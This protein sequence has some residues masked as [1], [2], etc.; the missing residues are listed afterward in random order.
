MDPSS[1]KYVSVILVNWNGKKYLTEV[2]PTLYRQTYA[3]LEIIVV[4]NA[5][6]DGT[7]DYI[8]TEHPNVL[9]IKNPE[10][11]GFCKANNQGIRLSKGGYVLIMNPDVQLREDFIEKMVQAMEREEK[12]GI[13]SGK[14]FR[15]K[16]RTILDTTGIVLKKNR[17]AI[18][19]GQGESDG[20]R[21]NQI[22]EI[23]GASGAACLYRREMLEAVKFREEYLDELFFAYKEDVDLSWRARLL[24]WK[25][26]YTPY[27][28]GYH[29]RTWFQGNRKQVPRWIRRHSLKN[30]Y[31]M[32]I[33]ND[34][35][36]EIRS[37]LKDFLWYELKSLIYILFREPHLFKALFDVIRLLP[38]VLEK[39]KVIQE[40]AKAG[41]KDLI[42]WFQL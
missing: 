6:T 21:Y 35:W 38:Q 23:F 32:L 37:C 12:I 30:R 22:E 31:L 27:A 8:E 13:V 29:D 17:R 14:L 4:D 36:S 42:R 15:E 19:R 5:S 10:N 11:Y 33:K 26:L 24:G 3:P 40:R 20:A 41:H 34:R 2:L 28:I 25:C 18:D 9:L 7:A 16:E 39:R 1:K